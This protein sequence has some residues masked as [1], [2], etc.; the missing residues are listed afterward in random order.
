MQ[1]RPEELKGTE[2][3]AVSAKILDEPHEKPKGDFAR[4]QGEAGGRIE[5][6]QS[7]A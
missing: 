5:R 7:P 6:L 3:A 4:D 2:T 1:A